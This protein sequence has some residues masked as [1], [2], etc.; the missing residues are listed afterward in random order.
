MSDAE[1]STVDWR[2]LVLVSQQEVAPT[3]RDLISNISEE[4]H[5]PSEVESDVESLPAL[6]PDNTDN[7][8]SLAHC[9][10]LFRC[11]SK[12][13]IARC[14]RRVGRIQVHPKPLSSPNH[15]HPKIISSKTIS[16]RKRF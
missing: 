10:P 11:R 14:G 5:V 13:S 1:G 15:F 12:G 4:S 6:N 9:G 3:V 8:P 7:E 16:S 2:R